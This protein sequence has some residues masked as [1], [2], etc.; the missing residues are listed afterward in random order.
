MF[1]SGSPTTAAGREDQTDSYNRNDVYC[2]GMII[3]P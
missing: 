1:P 2:Q 3:A